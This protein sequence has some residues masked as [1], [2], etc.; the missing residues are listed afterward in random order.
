MVSRLILAAGGEIE[1]EF[2]DVVV[3]KWAARTA[4][5]P[6]ISIEIGDIARILGPTE[7]GEVLDAATCERALSAL[8]IRTERTAPGRYAAKLPSW[9]LDLEREVDLIEEIARLYGYNRFADTLPAFSGSVVKQPEAE[10]ERTLRRR[11]LGAGYFEAIGAT[12]SS[13]REAAAFARLPNSAVQMENPLSDEAGYLRT[14]LIP[15]MLTMLAHNL[16]REAESVRLFEMGFVFTA[17]G[18]RVTETRSLSLGATGQAARQNPSAPSREFSFYDMK[19]VVE[20]ILSAFATNAIDWDVFPAEIGLMPVWLDLNFAAR[21]MV[22]G[23]TLG[24]FGQIAAAEAGDRKLRQAVFVGEIYL[25]R[26]FRHALREPEVREISRFPA[27][28]RDIS[29]QFPAAIRWSQIADAIESLGIRELTSI[30]PHEIVRD[31]SLSESA[32]ADPETYFLVLRVV[33]QAQDRTLRLDELQ[34]WAH[35]IFSHL[36]ELGGKPRFPAELL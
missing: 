16:N 27:V 31:P 34:D 11:L 36:M 10:K 22:D 19:G 29:F 9:R 18:D 2:V 26:L 23:E 7:T 1:G 35:R 30:Q 4:E 14:S 25:D 5:R 28:Q 12:F 32:A 33:F 8:G 3:P 13:E 17:N 6:P 21:I 20:D 15:G 24:Y